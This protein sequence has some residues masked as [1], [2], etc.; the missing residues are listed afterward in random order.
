MADT[1]I[2]VTTG[3]DLPGTGKTAFFELVTAGGRRIKPVLMAMFLIVGLLITGWFTA[4][5]ILDHN[6][7]FE[8]L[9]DSKRTRLIKELDESV[10]VESD[11]LRVSL[12]GLREITALKS[13]FLSGDRESLLTLSQPLYERLKQDFD[14]THF[15]FTRPDRFSFLRVHAPN[16]HGDLIERVTTLR[17]LDS[18]QIASGIEIGVH[19]GATLRIVAPWTAD[20]QLI[21]FI[22]IGKEIDNV[23]ARIAA[24]E[25]VTAYGLVRKQLLDETAWRNRATASSGTDDWHVLDDYVLLG[26]TGEKALS[27]PLLHLAQGNV[28]EN[29]V[30]FSENG[31]Y[32]AATSIPTFDILEHEVG[33]ILFAWD[34]S[35][36]QSEFNRQLQAALVAVFA[37]MFVSMLIMNRLLGALQYQVDRAH[38]NLEQNVASGQS[39]LKET[40][41]RLLEESRERARAEGQSNFFGRI[42][43]DSWNEIYIF[44]AED[45]H[46]LHVNRGALANMGYSHEEMHEQTAYGIKPDF[47]LET[48]REAIAPLVSGEKK[49]LVFEA[50]HRRKHGTIYPV[51]VRLQYLAE[52]SPPVFVAVINDITKRKRA[53]AQILQLNASLEERVELRTRELKQAQR[54]LVESE[55]MASLGSLV[56][57]VAHEINT[58]VGIGVTAAS[59]L[60]DEFNA[61]SK[62]YEADEMTQEDFDKFLGQ[63]GEAVQI[64]QHNL[65]RASDL[66]RSFKQVAADQNMVEPREIDT[67]RYLSDL[68]LSLQ[69]QLKQGQHSIEIECPEDLVITTCPGSLS[70]VVTN[71]V[72]NAVT[73]GFKERT[74]GHMWLRLIQ[75]QGDKVMLLFRD[76]GAGIAPEILERIFEPFVTSNR[77]GGGTGLGMHIVHNIVTQTFGGSI[78]VFSEPG[79][80]TVIEI[81]MPQSIRSAAPDN[82]VPLAM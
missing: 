71:L 45:F 70:Q 72:T 56:A 69:P 65:T 66:I 36:A 10:L 6:A 32:F 2:E 57:G 24:T 81:V 34:M 44:D 73:H 25:G 63:A 19:G 40:T 23:V 13:A 64:L 49:F 80:G 21:G 42:L 11:A 17:A 53:E 61:L 46:F 1:G 28:A 78:D 31:K 4:S 74:G 62:R 12:V 60:A 82:V 39:A 68:L 14:V 37:I 75:D 41:E 26:S 29:R 77:A 51:E 9:V 5:I 33:K 3:A 22:E 20:G 38:A 79:E 54:S 67:K 30:R 58:P 15:Y 18:G 16:L 35:A 27:A 50:R 48:F 8:S 59:H 52:E 47:T 55:K 76:D 7:R 43:E